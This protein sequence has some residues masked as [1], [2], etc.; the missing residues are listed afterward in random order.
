[1]DIVLYFIL[2]SYFYFISHAH[3]DREKSRTNTLNR[4]LEIKLFKCGAFILCALRRK[5]RERKKQESLVGAYSKLEEHLVLSIFKK[6]YVRVI[7]NVFYYLFIS[8]ILFFAFFVQAGKCDHIKQ[9][10]FTYT[11]HI[12]FTVLEDEMHS[13]CPKRRNITT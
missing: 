7:L 10:T 3:C 13:K 2:D 11:V 5:D 9:V 4:Q 1:M 6:K 8:F 12:L